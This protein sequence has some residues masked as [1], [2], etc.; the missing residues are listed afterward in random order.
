MEK[1]SYL[2]QRQQV[3][4]DDFNSHPDKYLPERKA[5]CLKR[6]KAI[7][8]KYIEYSILI[9]HKKM[10]P[11]GVMELIAKE[12]NTSRQNINSVLKSSGIYQDRL[13]PIVIPDNFQFEDD[14]LSSTKELR[15]YL[16]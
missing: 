12:Y 8:K 16:S 5:N 9:T 13:N 2:S 1:N 15:F 4:M 11:A 7:V 14:E 3:I 10:T 6:N